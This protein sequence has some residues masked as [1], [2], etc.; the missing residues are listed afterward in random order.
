LD[1]KSK[2]QAKRLAPEEDV[3]FWTT[4][5]PETDESTNW[6]RFVA[7]GIL[8]S[9][10]CLLL[11]SSAFAQHCD[12]LILQ[13]ALEDTRLGYHAYSNRCEGFYRAT[14]SSQAFTV[15]GLT[16]G[17]LR[18]EIDPGEVLEIALPHHRRA[19]RIRALPIPDKTYYRMDAALGA[20][21]KLRWPIRD[22]ILKR[23]Y[24]LTCD[25]MGVLAIDGDKDGDIYLPVRALPSKAPVVTDKRFHLVLSLSYDF[26]DFKYRTIKSPANGQKIVGAWEDPSEKKRI[27]RL[28]SPLTILLSPGLVGI[29]D[30]E[31]AGKIKN[32][33][34]WMTRRLRL[35]LGH[36]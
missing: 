10:L 27:Y 19:V 33:E 9:V 26:A 18:Y 4:R 21:K 31:V 22:V 28:G 29:V 17:P 1:L 20:A 15:V 36:H 34:N 6:R 23:P 12:P 7:I 13:H 8:L 25:Q 35:D 16:I 30:V 24:E 2:R 32:Q 5:H 11:E 14:V 3:I